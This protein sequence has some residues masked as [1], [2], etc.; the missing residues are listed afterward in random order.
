MS[1]LA[2]IIE[3]SENNTIEQNNEVLNTIADYST[4]LATFV[5]DSDMNINDTVSMSLTTLFSR[6]Y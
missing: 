5:G 4:E 1:V 3:Q 2:Q 6:Q